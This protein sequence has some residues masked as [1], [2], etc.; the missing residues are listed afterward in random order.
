MHLEVDGNQLVRGTSADGDFEYFKKVALYLEVVR[1]A[2]FLAG[3]YNL[4]CDKFRKLTANE[5]DDIEE[6]Y[7]LLA[8]G[9]HRRR[10]SIAKVC[11]AKFAKEEWDKHQHLVSQDVGVINRLKAEFP[12]K[13]TCTMLGQSVDLENV[14]R[15]FNFLNA[16]A[17]GTAAD[18]SIRAALHTSELSEYILRTAGTPP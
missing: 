17:I 1:K 9:E 2:R 11:E 14:V 7:D 6:L 3:R 16:T 12:V 5:C 13:V 8:K 18:G 10:A 4:T 15:E